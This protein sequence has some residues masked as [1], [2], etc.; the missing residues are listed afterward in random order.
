M[1][2]VFYSLH[3]GFTWVFKIQNKNW[4]ICNS[5]LKTL[6]KINPYNQNRLPVHVFSFISSFTVDEVWLCS[7]MF[8]IRSSS[9]LL[10]PT[11]PL[12][13]QPVT[14]APL[15]N[16][17]FMICHDISLLSRIILVGNIFTNFPLHVVQHPDLRRSKLLAYCIAVCVFV[18]VGVCWG[19]IV[20]APRRNCVRP[21]FF[22][23]HSWLSG[24]WR[25]KSRAVYQI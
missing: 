15:I 23:L 20:T 6:N 8:I 1:F 19:C 18:C 7:A 14:G 24:K 12:L 16:A 21:F 13:L 22:P 9:T 3:S 25:S 11:H 4:N 5:A 2:C 17:T 10:I